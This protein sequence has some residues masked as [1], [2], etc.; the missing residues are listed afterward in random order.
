MPYMVTDSSGN[1]I[2]TF[3]FFSTLLTVTDALGTV[4]T[5]TKQPPQYIYDTFRDSLILKFSQAGAL[6]SKVTITG[7]VDEFPGGL[8]IDSLDN[9]YWWGW[10]SS[11]DIQ[12]VNADGSIGALT[13]PTTGLLVSE[14]QGGAYTLLVKF[15]SSGSSVWG[16]SGVVTGDDLFP[17]SL[18][19]QMTIPI[20]VQNSFLIVKGSRYLYFFSFSGDGGFTPQ[21]FR[22]DPIG[23]PSTSF[24][25]SMV[26]EYAHLSQP[27]V[28]YFESSIQYTPFEH[29]QSM[30]VSIL[31][32]K[33][34]IVLPFLNLIKDL[35][36]TSN[37]LSA[38][39][40]TFNGEDL[41]NF[42]GDYFGKIIPFETEVNMPSVT[43]TYKY[44]FGTPV[45]FS[46][47]Q[48]KVLTITQGS[49]TGFWI[50]AKTINVL[51]VGNGVAGLLFNSWQYLV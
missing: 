14:Q 49:T 26:I 42:S 47:I 51:G 1:I 35:Y 15:N 7:N 38:M 41:F 9:L 19:T 28:K 31:P 46:R 12:V 21:L 24:I 8:G 45:N 2:F 43:P 23:P 30:F 16:A 44:T 6:L 22:Y 39:Q 37:T 27:E 48:S 32:G 20:S 50:Y 4:T 5:F 3:S 18:G 33:T 25:S 17:T 40:L 11:S 36:V 13:F 29:M 34:Q 10:Y